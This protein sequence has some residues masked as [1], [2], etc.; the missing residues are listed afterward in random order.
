MRGVHLR[1]A[2]ELG[3]RL[4][5]EPLERELVERVPALP[6]DHKIRGD[7]DCFVMGQRIYSQIRGDLGHFVMRI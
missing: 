2:L 5:V 6:F 1:P 7:L 4:L 3:S